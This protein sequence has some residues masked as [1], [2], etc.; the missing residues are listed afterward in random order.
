M[1]L[2]PKWH[3]PKRAVRVVVITE[4]DKQDVVGSLPIEDNNQAILWQYEDFKGWKN[5]CTN[6]IGELN[7]AVL[8]DKKEVT[9]KAWYPDAWLQMP[10]HTKITVDLENMKQIGRRSERKVRVVHVTP[11][12]QKGDEG[13]VA[14]SQHTNMP[15]WSTQGPR[16]ENPEQDQ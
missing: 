3:S 10:R 9:L 12:L 13:V 16:I 6:H 1:N 5:F 4:C 2:D 11:I 8:A 14:P 15:V 7:Q